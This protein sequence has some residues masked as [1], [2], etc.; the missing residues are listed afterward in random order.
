MKTIREYGMVEPGDRIVC[1]VSGGADSTA[2]LYALFSLQSLLQIELCAAHLNH[3]LRGEEAQRD[4][5]FVQALCAKLGIPC[6]CGSA[7]VGRLSKQ[8]RESV[9]LA[10]RNARYAFFEK[11]AAQW[12]AQ[13]IATAH[14]ADDNLETML[15][16]LTRGTALQGLSGIPPVRGSYI[17]PLIDVTR[18]AVM[19]YLKKNALEYV[20]DS[21][22]A[23]R[24]YTRNRVRLDVV[25][26][27]RRINP[28]ASQA[29]R[30]TARMLREDQNFLDALARQ[31]VGPITREA[32][33]VYV[34]T[35]R[36]LAFHPALRRRAVLYLARTALNVSNYYL[37]FERICDIIR[38]AQN[39]SPSATLCLPGGLTVRRRY[40]RLFFQKGSRG[41]EVFPRIV[42][43]PGAHV[44]C[45]GYEIVC[46]LR[47]EL[48]E[49]DKQKTVLVADHVEKT[50]IVLRSRLPGDRIRLAGRP[51]KTLKRL[52]ID[53]KIPLQE[54][55]QIPVL[56]VDGKLVGVYGFGMDQR[57]F[58]KY[59][60]EIVWVTLRRLNQ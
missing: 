12:K 23:E 18:G 11:T 24:L 57:M 27:L 10:A 8:N 40:D 50:E 49:P 51:E 58:P 48:P 47:Q 54:R 34:G 37:E 3:M 41:P 60:A 45:A 2:M 35:D 33:D 14:T 44:T 36:L 29:A 6:I 16:H 55:D 52:F 9:E 1:G 46:E 39:K 19:D 13:K 59:S 32:D 17:R 56:E 21:T 20:E 42:L 26:E 4:Q 7:D 15:M 43:H 31:A 30:R 38:L 28:K 5:K 22:N 53:E 25:G